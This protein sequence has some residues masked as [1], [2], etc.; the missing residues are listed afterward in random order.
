MHVFIS[1][2]M[3]GGR[4]DHLIGDQE[5][6]LQ[7]ARALSE[8]FADVE[9][10]D[11]WTL[12]PNSVTYSE[13]EGRQAFYHMIEMAGEADLLIAYLPHVS[14][15]TAMEMWEAHCKNTYVIAITP[16]VHHW[17]I[18]FTADEILPDLEALLQSIR[19]GRLAKALGQI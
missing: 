7:I 12:H 2:V 1:G 19:D 15:G 10:T 11:P 5:Y 3:Q 16:H 4:L 17:A 13:E 8:Q 9:I 18:R 14:M 6:R